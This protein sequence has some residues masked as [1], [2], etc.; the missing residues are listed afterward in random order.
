MYDSIESKRW[1]KFEKYKK[2]CISD[3]INESIIN[4]NTERGLVKINYKYKILEPHLTYFSGKEFNFF[5]LELDSISK[6]KN[7]DTIIFFRSDK[8]E[9]LIKLKEDKGKC[10]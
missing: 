3:Q 4:I 5:Q 6:N 8:K 7:S 2:I 10:K 1:K 9:I